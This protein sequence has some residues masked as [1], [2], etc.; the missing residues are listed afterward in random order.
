M[1]KVC[2]AILVVLTVPALCAWAQD[3]PAG[4][5]NR[6]PEPQG[7][8][9]MMG[10]RPLPPLIAALDVNGDRAIDEKELANAPQA[11][12]ALDKNGDG[13]L[14]VEEYRPAHA[15]WQGSSAEA[16]GRRQDMRPGM[17]RPGGVLGG[18]GMHPHSP[19]VAALDANGDG[20]IDAEE[21][22]DASV[23]LKKLDKNGDGKI[24][25]DE[26]RPQRP[27]VEKGSGAPAGQQKD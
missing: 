11:L 24:T 21:I 5:G 1:K 18:G 22:A 2:I 16:G 9:G 26:I 6:P 19:L 25:V 10:A 14:A 23:S 15:G 4:Q 17:N 12:K 27:G 7:G 13:K 8:Q 3:Q 20:T